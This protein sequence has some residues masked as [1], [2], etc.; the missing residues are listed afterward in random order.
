MNLNENIMNEF[1]NNNN[2][3]NGSLKIA[4]SP[5]RSFANSCSFEMDT[6]PFCFSR[7][8][9]W[10][11]FRFLALLEVRIEKKNKDLTT[12]TAELLLNINHLLEAVSCKAHFATRGTTNINSQRANNQNQPIRF[13]FHF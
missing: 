3:R 9:S 8:G 2:K 1:K 10:D 13:H 6:L 11:T 7:D 5:S 4:L 12:L